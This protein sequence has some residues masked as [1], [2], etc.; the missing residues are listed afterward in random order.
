MDRGRTLF[1]HMSVLVKKRQQKR[2]GNQ[3]TLSYACWLVVAIQWYRPEQNNANTTLLVNYT[4]H[5]GKIISESCVF[6]SYLIWLGL[7]LKH[8][9]FKIWRQFNFGYWKTN[10]KVPQI[11]QLT[12]C[13][14][15]FIYESFVRPV[16]CKKVVPWCEITTLCNR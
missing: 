6:I 8:V 14:L 15:W 13:P 7:I 2:V 3:L 1:G 5:S 9:K 4:R 10:L 16:C 12:V 11:R